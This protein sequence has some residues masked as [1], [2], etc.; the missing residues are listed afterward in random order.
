MSSDLQLIGN[1]RFQQIFPPG[2]GRS[3]QGLNSSRAG[4]SFAC[5]L[6]V[7]ARISFPERVETFSE[8]SVEIFLGKEDQSLAVCIF[9]NEK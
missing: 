9:K 1:N 2:C 8:R 4:T 3:A 6:R 5:H 7:C